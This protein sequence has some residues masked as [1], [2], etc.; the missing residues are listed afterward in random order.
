MDKSSRFRRNPDYIFREIV[1]ES[2]LVPTGKASKQFQGVG[3]MNRTGAFL[4]ELLE[5]ERSLKE[6]S[7]LFAVEYGLTEEQSQQDVTEF[8]EAAQSYD[9]ILLC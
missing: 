8:L 5:Q 6:L 9:A 7:E 2:M 1:G 4:W 3:T